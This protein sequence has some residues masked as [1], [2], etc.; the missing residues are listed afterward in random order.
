MSEGARAP[1]PVH[2]RVLQADLQMLP[3]SLPAERVSRPLK[4]ERVSRSLR[5]VRPDG[6]CL[7][8]RSHPQY[9]F[10]PEGSRSLYFFGKSGTAAA[11]AVSEA[12]LA[13]ALRARERVTN[14]ESCG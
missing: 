2:S 1:I 10:K 6:T 7:R 14:G 8:A 4:A 11:V 12:S 3:P 9:T 13:A 5:L